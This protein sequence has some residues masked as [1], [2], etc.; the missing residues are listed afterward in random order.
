MRITPDD[1]YMGHFQRGSENVVFLWLQVFQAND[2]FTGLAAMAEPPLSKTTLSP[3][4]ARGAQ[5]A[6]LVRSKLHA[7]FLVRTW[8]SRMSALLWTG[9]RRTPHLSV[10]SVKQQIFTFTIWHREKARRVWTCKILP[11]GTTRSR[12]E[13]GLG[14]EH[15]SYSVVQAEKWPESTKTQCD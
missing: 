2:C 13:S 10:I 7:V 9:E 3:G 15:S 11:I 1:A 8:S 4:G 5:A 14:P 6:A 12:I